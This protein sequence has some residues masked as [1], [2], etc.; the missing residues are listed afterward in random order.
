M[1][2]R[3]IDRAY[4][5]YCRVAA[6]LFA[7]F[8]FY[9]LVTK[10]L[11]HRLAHDWAHTALHLLSGLMAAYAG[12]LASGVVP[13]RLF[14]RA[15]ALS[16]GILGVVGWFIDGLFLNTQVAIPLDPVA[17]LFHLVLAGP[18]LAI[19]AAHAAGAGRR[20]ASAVRQPLTRPA[21]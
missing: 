18:A 19:V 2:S 13:A 9:P 16:Y 8:T 10:V 20:P 7:G 4:L 15:V 5:L 17:N 3:G 14:T 6:I 21:K 1:P 11:E 12:W